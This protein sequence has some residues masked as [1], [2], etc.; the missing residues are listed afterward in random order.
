MDAKL[1]GFVFNWYFWSLITPAS[2]EPGCSPG[3][4][5]ELE[6]QHR[7]CLYVLQTKVFK[8]R[9]VLSKALNEV[10]CTPDPYRRSCLPSAVTSM[11]SLQQ[12]IWRAIV[13][14]YSDLV[15]IH[16]HIEKKWNILIC[17]EQLKLYALIYLTETVSS[18]L[19]NSSFNY[20]LIVVKWFA[21]L[22]DPQSQ[23]LGGIFPLVRFFK[24]GTRE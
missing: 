18:K 21:C 23:D 11:V 3:Q 1:E 20:G 13:E 2:S 24:V 15:C 10:C 16:T 6:V 8:Q 4:Q 14:H 9:S 17:T 7:S 22:N 5:T 12:L 19:L